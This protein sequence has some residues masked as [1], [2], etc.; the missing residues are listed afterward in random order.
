MA[1]ES[2]EPNR[3]QDADL[4][5]EVICKSS[6]YDLWTWFSVFIEGWRDCSWKQRRKKE[7]LRKRYRKYLE[8][9][10][11]G[12]WEGNLDKA[13][14]YEQ[15]ISKC[16]VIADA[17]SEDEKEIEDKILK[18]FREML[19]VEPHLNGRINFI[20]KPHRRQLDIYF[21]NID[22]PHWHIVIQEEHHPPEYVEY[23][24][25]KMV[26]CRPSYRSHKDRRNRQVC[27]IAT[28]P[29]PTADSLASPALITT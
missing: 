27:V 14:E 8:K 19:N 20:D 2:K 15:L 12:D 1:E 7:K 4:I 10:N 13:L 21:G 9:I 3:D 26:Y 29:A 17:L 5:L 11:A 25:Y 28:F 6:N 18:A 24:S 23:P 16:S 22:E